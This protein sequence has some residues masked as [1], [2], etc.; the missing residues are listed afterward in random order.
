MGYSAGTDATSR[1]DNV[2]DN[3]GLA[4]ARMPSATTRATIYMGPPAASL[5]IG[6]Q[7]IDPASDDELIRRGEQ[8]LRRRAGSAGFDQMRLL[9]RQLSLPVSTMSQW[10][11]SRS[12]TALVILASPN[13]EG[14]SLGAILE[15][16]AFA[17]GD[18]IGQPGTQRSRRERR[19]L[20]SHMPVSAQ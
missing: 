5:G 18:A 2:F 14:H 13:T 3:D 15:V 12:R 16:R 9:K 7:N 4:K 6:V 11:M 10:W 19:R 1:P 8:G 17:C 20:V